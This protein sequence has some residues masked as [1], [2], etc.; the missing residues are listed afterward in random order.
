[1]IDKDKID[2]VFSIALPEMDP[3]ERE[4]YENS[5]RIYRH[6]KTVFTGPFA[7]RNEDMQNQL[8]E[9]I[10]RKADLALNE[11]KAH[12]DKSC[13]K[14]EIE[15][16]IPS[17][18]KD[19]Q[20][21]REHT[22]GKFLTAQECKD[23]RDAAQALSDARFLLA[24]A[25]GLVK[26]ENNTP[27][28]TS[29]EL[30]IWIEV[31]NQLIKEGILKIRILNGCSVYV[32]NG[33]RFKK[34][35]DFNNTVSRYLAKNNKT[36]PMQPKATYLSTFIRVIGLYQPQG[37]KQY[38]SALDFKETYLDKKKKKSQIDKSIKDNK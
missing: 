29:P 21:C 6:P 8:L 18:Q 27:L 14:D 17:M 3:D 30:I 25:S 31:A 13:W 16:S 2:S 32:P 34:A 24:Y 33:T 35:S 36:I 38:S 11:S 15:K 10:E 4:S 37:I 20:L 26:Q 1:M 5:Y 28:V 22:E 23:L 9:F 7:S 12:P 19:L